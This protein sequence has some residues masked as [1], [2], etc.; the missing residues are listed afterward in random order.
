MGTTW[1]P[2]PPCERKPIY[3]S[4]RACFQQK[5][6]KSNA[7]AEIPWFSERGPQPAS[8]R[9][10]YASSRTLMR[11]RKGVEGREAVSP[12]A[13]TVEARETVRAKPPAVAGPSGWTTET[14]ADRQR[15]CCH[16]IHTTL[17]PCKAVKVV[18]CAQLYV[19]SRAPAGIKRR[20]GRV[21]AR[22]RR[23]DDLRYE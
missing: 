14:E 1:L 11:T 7:G 16:R 12:P 10:E 5:K 20:L 15:H 9:E 17:H 19:S 23:S 18:V 22:R 21:T 13:K 4:Q 2:R 3:S 8:R 6:K